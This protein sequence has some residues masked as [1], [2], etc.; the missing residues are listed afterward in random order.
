MP[1]PKGVDRRVDEILNNDRGHWF[2]TPMALK[3]QRQTDQ[4]LSGYETTDEY[5]AQFAR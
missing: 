3:R 4:A 2:E 5:K 1:R